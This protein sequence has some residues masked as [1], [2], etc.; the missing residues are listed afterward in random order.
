MEQKQFNNRLNRLKRAKK[1][2]V[3]NLV[4]TPR[5]IAIVL[6]VYLYRALTTQQISA[7]VFAKDTRSTQCEERLKRLYHNGYLERRSQGTTYQDNKPLVYMLTEKGAQLLS[8][9]KGMKRNEI[10]W[11]AKYNTISNYHLQHVVQ[12][13]ESRISF[14]RA[15][16]RLGYELSWL[17]EMSIRHHKLYDT[18]TYHTPTGWTKKTTVI[19]DSFFTI[20]TP[21]KLVSCFL[22]IDR[23][24]ETLSTVADKFSKYVSYLQ[25]EEYLTRYAAFDEEGNE[26]HPF[27]LTITT[28]EQRMNN[29][30]EVASDVG[31]DD[32]YMFSTFA[33]TTPERV[34]EDAVWKSSRCDYSV[35]LISTP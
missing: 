28:T 18:F 11:N 25:T 22:E 8:E 16:E 17:D 12:T 6:A 32:I 4:L 5:D 1:G 13:S 21:Q 27:V 2:N 26:I 31:A 15:C 30:L 7:L 35:P 20:E 23:G 29:L 24:T 3:P 34:L 33:D 19:P 10:Y 14:V 9:H